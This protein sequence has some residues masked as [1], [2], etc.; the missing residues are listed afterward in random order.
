MEQA[1]D[2]EMSDDLILEVDP[3]FSCLSKN[4]CV[5]TMGIDVQKDRLA[6]EVIGHNKTTDRRYECE[7]FAK[8]MAG[9]KKTCRDCV[10]YGVVMGIKEVCNFGMVGFDMRGGYE[11]CAEFKGRDEK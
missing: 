4:N 5:L 6:I 9:M 3:C 11:P 10:N 2:T 7:M 1:G 8:Y